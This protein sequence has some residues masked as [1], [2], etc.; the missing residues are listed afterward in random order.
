MLGGPGPEFKE[1]Q[2][3]QVFCLLVRDDVSNQT[4]VCNQMKTQTTS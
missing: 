1:K 2:G 4:A 3:N